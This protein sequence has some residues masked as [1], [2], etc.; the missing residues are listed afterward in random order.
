[1][2][3]MNYMNTLLKY[4]LLL[5]VIYTISVNAQNGLVRSYYSNGSLESA[6]NYINDVLDGTSLYFYEDGVLKEE[7]TYSMGVLNG[8]IKTYYENGAPKDEFYINEGK[9]DGVAREYYNNGGLKIFSI[10]ENGKL[11]QTQF[12]QYD[13]TLAPP[14]KESIRSL[15]N[16]REQA[17]KLNEIKNGNKPL[18]QPVE[19]IIKG[20]KQ[21]SPK[22]IFY[23]S[24][25]EFPR[26]LGG[27]SEV[28]SN[29]VYPETAKQNKVQ[30]I[31]VIK[32]FIDKTGTVVNTEVIKSIGSGCEEA[33]IAAVK[34]TKFS[35]A[36]IN[37]QPVG[38]QILIPLKFKLE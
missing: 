31:V 36:K 14:A 28:F 19:A 11:K 20:N 24:V 27:P 2:H 22:E 17:R 30:G 32:A 5:L 6:I 35:P 26:P 1:M 33:A 8:W 12:V 25:D 29:L 15:A 7:S 37:N 4:T 23:S 13:S 10:Y 9:K 34:K 3:M 38:S 18:P 16:A 21:E